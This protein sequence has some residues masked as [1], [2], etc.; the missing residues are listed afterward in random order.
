LCL[1]SNMKQLPSGLL[2]ILKRLIRQPFHIADR[3][4]SV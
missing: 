3:Y 4:R 2:L 1:T